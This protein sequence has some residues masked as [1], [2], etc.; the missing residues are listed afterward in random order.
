MTDTQENKLKFPLSKGVAALWP[1]GVVTIHPSLRASPLFQ[2][3]GLR[4]EFP[5]RV[6][7]SKRAREL[8][9]SASPYQL[10]IIFVFFIADYGMK[11][12]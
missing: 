5:W 9:M 8:G 12:D 10:L 7:G 4:G 3:R 11:K 2:E 6:L 1:P